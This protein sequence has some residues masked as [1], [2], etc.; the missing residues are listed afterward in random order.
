MGKAWKRMLAI[1]LVCCLTLP[2]SGFAGAGVSV[3]VDTK[4]HPVCQYRS[5]DEIIRTAAGSQDEAKQRYGGQYLMVV[6]VVDEISKN[7]SKVTLVSTNPAQNG[8]IECSFS[9]ED[10]KSAQR[11]RIG[12]QAAVYGRFLIGTFDKKEKIAAIHIDTPPAET[13]SASNYYLADVAGG[14]MSGSAGLG[15]GRTGSGINPADMMVRTLADGRVTYRIPEEW[16]AV[17]HDLQAEGLGTIPGRQYV[18]NKTKTNKGNVPESLFICYFENS[19]KNLAR[20]SD[21][22]KTKEIEKAIIRNISGKDADTFEPSSGKRVST[23]YGANYDYYVG[24]HTDNIQGIG[25]HAE[26]IFQPDGTDGFVVYLYI[27]QEEKHLADVLFVTRFL[28]VH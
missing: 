21:A 26:Y 24:R 13:L 18:L 17:E 5:A 9:G 6:G 3:V 28:E 27:Y 14:S 1:V 10:R 19:G 25:Y 2:I 16:E 22:K 15:V 4:A 8:S 11:F 20:T 23:Y 7:G 12:D